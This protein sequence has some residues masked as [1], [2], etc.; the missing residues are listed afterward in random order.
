MLPARDVDRKVGSIGVL[1]PNWEARL[2]IDGDGD[3]DVE[4]ADGQ[5]GEMWVRGHAVMKVSSPG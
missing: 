1:L 5:A 3:G 2:L 4:A